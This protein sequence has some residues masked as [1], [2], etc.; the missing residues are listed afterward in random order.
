MAARSV[1]RL[2]GV[3]RR[4]VRPVAVVAPLDMRAAASRSV[5][6][7]VADY[8]AAEDRGREPPAIIFAIAMPVVTIAAMAV[9]P[10]VPAMTVETSAVM[11]TVKAAV[12]ATPMTIMVA[13][14]TK[15][16]TMTSTQ[17]GRILALCRRRR[18]H[19]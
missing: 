8:R 3:V 16:A 7:G 18:Y 11:A 13:G 12:M 14:D 15:V 19:R 17:A 10:A 6:D 5:D 4:A 1:V 9:V 2:I